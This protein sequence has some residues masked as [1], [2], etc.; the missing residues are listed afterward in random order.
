MVITEQIIQK[1]QTS[2]KNIYEYKLSAKSHYIFWH[3]I[4]QALFEPCLSVYYTV[5]LEN[6]QNNYTGEFYAAFC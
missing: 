1:L 3:I 4:L 6:S 2:Q 5:N